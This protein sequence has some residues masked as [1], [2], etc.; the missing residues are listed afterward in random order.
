M[1]PW[2]VASALSLLLSA[3]LPAAAQII[4]DA[5]HNAT[6]I[7]GTWTSQSRTVLTGID[8]N[9]GL[10]FANPSNTSFTYPSCTGYG[11]AF[12][13][14]GWYEVARYRFT[15]NATEHQCI[16]GALNWAHGNYELLSNGS[17]VFNPLGDGF[18]LVQDPC[19]ARSIFVENFNDTELYQSWR[20][21]DDPTDG[22]KLHL[23]AFD[24]SPIN[25]LYQV[26]TEPNMLPLQMLR[27]VTPEFQAQDGFVNTGKREIKRSEPQ[28]GAAGSRLGDVT[29]VSMLLSVIAGGLMVTL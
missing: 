14:D 24:G 26:S 29:S 1:R 2:Q 6:S 16:I 18:Q 22:P 12:T 11:Y 23:F 20:I 8:P 9:T 21:F 7:T 5:I 27:N 13:D 4:F 19:G 28:T 17:I 10:A 3:S 15:S 25:P